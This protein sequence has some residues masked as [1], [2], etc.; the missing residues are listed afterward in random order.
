M[1]RGSV[2]STLSRIEKRIVVSFVELLLKA[3]AVR[4]KPAFFGNPRT[5]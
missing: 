3:R 4:F 1:K 2:L 5:T